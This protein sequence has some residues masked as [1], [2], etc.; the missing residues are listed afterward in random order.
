MCSWYEGYN[1]HEYFLCAFSGCNND[2]E[3]NPINYPAFITT[4]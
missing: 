2:I 4:P 1:E 3:I